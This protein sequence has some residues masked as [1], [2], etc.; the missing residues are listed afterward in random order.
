MSCL[1]MLKQRL[2]ISLFIQFHHV[3]CWITH[4]WRILWSLSQ[5]R[6]VLRSTQVSIKV[7]I[8]NMYLIIILEKDYFDSLLFGFYF[9]I[10][11]HVYNMHNI[12]YVIFGQRIRERKLVRYL[13][14][15]WKRTVTIY[16]DVSN[17]WNHE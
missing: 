12:Q 1:W 10:N 5:V 9:L 14:F 2:P 16:A 17:D 3:T 11:I 6:V 4:H 7:L 13:F 8:L 15:V